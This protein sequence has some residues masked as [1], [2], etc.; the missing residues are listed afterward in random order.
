MPFAPAADDGPEAFESGVERGRQT[1]GEIEQRE[2]L[3]NDRHCIPKGAAL[4]DL[5][6]CRFRRILRERRHTLRA[7]AAEPIRFAGGYDIAV[8][9]LGR[10]G[11]YTEQQEARWASFHGPRSQIERSEERRAGKECRSRWSP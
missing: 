5:R 7:E 2:R 11:L 6:Q 1:C 10:F 8:I 9:G 4:E 3:E